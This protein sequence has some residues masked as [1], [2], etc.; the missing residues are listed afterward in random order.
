[1]NKEWTPWLWFTHWVA[2]PFTYIL[3]ISHC[4]LFKSQWF[5]LFLYLASPHP[6]RVGKVGKCSQHYGKYFLS[7]ME[8]LEDAQKKQSCNITGVHRS[9][10][11]CFCWEDDLWHL[12]PSKDK[13]SYTTLNNTAWVQIRSSL[14]LRFWERRS[15]LRLARRIYSWVEGG[16][17]PKKMV[18]SI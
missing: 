15:I 13:L 1:M 6:F 12:R 14:H 11:H 17:H 16:Y 8:M 9:S 10:C 18:S 3:I 5:H 7:G 2:D 4:Y